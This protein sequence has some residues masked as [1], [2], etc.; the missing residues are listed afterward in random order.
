[1]LTDS[2]KLWQLDA[3]YGPGDGLAGPL[4]LPEYTLPLYRLAAKR[5][6][7]AV[8]VFCLLRKC[9]NPLQMSFD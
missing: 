5:M 3:K 6:L 9:E 4:S 2:A 7:K 1:M 8:F